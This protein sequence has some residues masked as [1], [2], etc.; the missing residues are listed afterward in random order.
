MIKIVNLYG[1][2]EIEDKEKMYRQTAYSNMKLRD[3]G[4]FNY[5]IRPRSNS[6]ANIIIEK[7]GIKKTIPVGPDGIVHITNGKPLRP[8][9]PNIAKTVIGMIWASWGGPTDEP[10]IAGNAA[11]GVRG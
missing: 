6:G 10:E 2:V 5:L 9:K 8:N 11:I 3:S 1:V 4:R 7:D